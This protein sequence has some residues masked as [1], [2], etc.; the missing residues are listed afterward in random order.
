MMPFAKL[1]SFLKEFT[2]VNS[3]AGA[4]ALS[5]TAVKAD[6]AATES[7]REKFT[8]RNKWTEK[9]IKTQPATVETMKAEVFVVDKYIAEQEDGA[10]RPVKSGGT[11]I[12]IEIRAAARIDEK[13]VI[14]QAYRAKS[15]QNGKKINKNRPFVA[16]ANNT[17]GVWVR[18]TDASYPIELLY[19]LSTT[20]KKITPRPWFQKPVED[21]YDKN[22]DPEYTRALDEQ[23][24]RLILKY[25]AGA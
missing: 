24:T 21:A 2:T 13:K 14:P 11:P 8:L 7:L 5:R 12:P 16:T 25:G 4:I 18:S 6:E 1:G 20:P 15:L 23:T 9:G 3:L 22:I 19:V 17:T 10:V